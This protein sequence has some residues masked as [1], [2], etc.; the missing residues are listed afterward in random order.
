MRRLIDFDLD[1]P[2]TL[3]RAAYEALSLAD[4]A[5]HDE[6]RLRWFGSGFLFGTNATAHLLRSV[7]GYLLMR[8]PDV[9]GSQ[10]I[11]VLTGPANVGK[12]TTLL[13][14]AKEVESHAGRRYPSFRAD[15]RAPVVLIEMS[16]GATSKGVA[17]SI[18]DFFAVPYRTH[19]THQKMIRHAAELMIY[20]QSSLL[21]VDEFQMVQLEGRR[22]DDAINTIKS[23]VNATGVVT[24]LAGIDLDQRLG[25]RAAEQLMAR[26]ETQRHSPFDYATDGDRQHWANL[27]AAFG[28]QMRLIDGPPDLAPYA[29]ALHAIT[30]GRIGALRRILGTALMIMLEEKRTPS[31]PEILSLEHLQAG[32]GP[33]LTDP[34]TPKGRAAA[35]ESNAA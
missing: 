25:S 28:V 26:G 23:I 4:R 1:E 21:V 10:R 19:D 18:L 30:A 13:Q 15:G 12:S 17:A 20:H 35:K 11:I 31:T 8:D 34:A 2:P 6:A 3:S 22:G 27:V 7:R 29:D 33:L 5:A 16:P 9:V 32:A 14:L 24:V